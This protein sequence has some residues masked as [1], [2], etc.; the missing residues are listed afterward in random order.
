MMSTYN[1]MDFGRKGIQ[2]IADFSFD[3][4]LRRKYDFPEHGAEHFV[5]HKSFIRSMYLKLGEVL[6]GVSKDGWKRNVT[7]ANSDWSGRV[8]K[9][10]YG[11]DCK[12]IYPPVWGDFPDIPWE[13]RENG[14]VVLARITPE[15]RIDNIIEIL[16]KVRETNND[17]HLHILG[18]LNDSAYGMKIRKLAEQN[19][20]WIFL[21]GLVTGQKKNGFYSKT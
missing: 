7:I 13:S 6:S 4:E 18:T 14:F 2:F 11:I 21:E 8:M 16:S 12:T 20:A 9:E 19:S 5:H 1:V 15:K 3:D 10:T 17:I